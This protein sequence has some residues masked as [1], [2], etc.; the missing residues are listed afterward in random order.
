MARIRNY[1]RDAVEGSGTFSGA[2]VSVS[3]WRKSGHCE[4]TIGNPKGDNPLSLYH[5]N[6]SG[7]M[8]VREVGGLV[9]L[10][11]G[12][13]TALYSYNAGTGFIPGESIATLENRALAATGPLTPKVNL[14]LF[15]YELKDVPRM[16]RHAGNLL[17]GIRRP[18][19]LNPLKE[20]AAGNLA[21]KFGWEPL[22]GDLGKLLGFA[23]AAKKRQQQLREAHTKRGLR[24]KVSLGELSAPLGI[25]NLLIWS[26]YGTTLNPKVSGM[27]TSKR[28]ATVRWVVRDQTQIGKTP[29][30]NESMRTILGLNKGH[31]P[32][33]IWK[34]IPWTWMED[35]FL[36]ISNVLTINYNSIYY[37]PSKLC[38]MVHSTLNF[39]HPTIPNVG[40]NPRNY[41]SAGFYTKEWKTRTVRPSP[42]ANV[43]LRLP[44]MDNYKLSV[45]GS[46]A[47]LKALKAR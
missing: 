27:C 25:S 31:L 17:H 11:P 3:E 32:I 37:K 23:D 21:Y 39:S 19:G 4:D 13:P 35:W 1:A 12:L 38:I 10:H 43:T 18:S 15:L 44:F 7:S 30:F 9:C 20:L 40:G 5:I 47:T 22:I 8:L 16:I 14:P 34:A 6:V 46:L 24:R 26:I 33:Q 36:D 45:L 2:P 41:C 42:T 29:T 28:W